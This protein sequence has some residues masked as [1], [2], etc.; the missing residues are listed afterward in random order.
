MFGILIGPRVIP[1]PPKILWNTPWRMASRNG[2]YCLVAKAGTTYSPL[3]NLA[4]MLSEVALPGPL[5]SPPAAM[6]RPPPLNMMRPPFLIVIAPP[7]APMPPEAAVIAFST[8]CWTMIFW[9]SWRTLTAKALNASSAVLV[10]SMMSWKNCSPAC[11]SAFVNWV[12]CGPTTSTTLRMLAS[13]S[14]ICAIWS[15]VK[16][17]GSASLN[18][19]MNASCWACAASRASFDRVIPSCSVI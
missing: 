6:A 4:G 10:P 2:R 12:I 3:D 18:C 5:T 1:L 14:S 19:S 13:N 16:V 7:R 9:I 17:P 8:S 15:S 11:C